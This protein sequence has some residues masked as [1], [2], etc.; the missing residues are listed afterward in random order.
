MELIKNIFFN[1]DKIVENTDIKI[2]YAGQL[3]QNGSDNVTIHYGFG[4]NWSNAQDIVMEKTELGYQANI[5]VQPDSKLNFC[6]KN[7]YGEWDNNNGANYEFKIEEQNI[8]EEEIQVEKENENENTPIAVYTT[9]SWGEL[10][11]KTFNN[12]VNYFSKLFGKQSV[13]N[14]I[15]K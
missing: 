7:S 2:T 9:P 13:E 5:H 11:K 3:F 6:F 10:F 4:D 12:F 1:T 14:E 8:I 15:K